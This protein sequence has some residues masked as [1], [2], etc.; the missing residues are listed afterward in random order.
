MLHVDYNIRASLF[1]VGD[2]FSRRLHPG[3]SLLKICF[4]KCLFLL[5][6][7]ILRFLQSVF[8]KAF[9]FTFSVDVPEEEK[10][11]EKL[12]GELFQTEETY[13]DNLKLV[14]EVS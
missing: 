10:K 8:F 6:R 1:Y 7:Y 9:S 12:I 3:F 2:L 11:R 14:Y 5:P 13:L 4:S